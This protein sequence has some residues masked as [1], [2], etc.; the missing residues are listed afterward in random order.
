MQAFHTL[1]KYKPNNHVTFILDELPNIGEIP[2]LLYILTKT[3]ESNISVLMGSQ[4]IQYLNQ[5]YSGFITSI[6]NLCEAIIF[7][8]HGVHAELN[9]YI[10]NMIKAI[11]TKD[12]PQDDSVKNEK[13]NLI[14]TQDIAKLTKNNCLVLIQD[15]PAIIDNKIKPL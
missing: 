5:R 1:L 14:S 6:E 10:E 3:A 7:F 9:S 15:M 2:D 13:R 12:N 11:Y 8:G 4:E